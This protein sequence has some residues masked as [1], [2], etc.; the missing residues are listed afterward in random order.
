MRTVKKRT[1]KKKESKRPPV[2]SLKIHY[3]V[4]D[5]GR[6]RIRFPVIRLS[7]IWLGKLGFAPDMHVT[8]T[9]MEKLLIIRLDE[10]HQE[11]Q[12]Q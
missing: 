6:D 5:S 3:D 7:G 11:Q 4:R 2:R 1:A 10:Q 12:Q 9:T 8:V